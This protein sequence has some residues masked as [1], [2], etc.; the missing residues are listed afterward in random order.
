MASGYSRLRTGDFDEGLHEFGLDDGGSA[1]NHSQPKPAGGGG[2]LLGRGM[3]VGLGLG[4]RTFSTGSNNNNSHRGGGGV[5]GED[6]VLQLKMREQDAN[7]DALGSSVSRLGEMSLNISKEIELQ[8]RMLESLEADTD[9]ARDKVDILT[10][11]TR[12]MVKKSGGWNNFC[13]IVFLVAV[14]IVLTLL[15]IYT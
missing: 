10:K 1:K 15:V 7:L 4:G 2:G 8:N 5:G 9:S 12:E 6:N 3:G 14:L 11:K 13:L